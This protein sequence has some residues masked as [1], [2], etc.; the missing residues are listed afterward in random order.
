M[1]L[2]SNFKDTSLFMIRAEKGEVYIK[3]QRQLHS[4]GSSAVEDFIDLYLLYFRLKRFQ[5]GCNFNGYFVF[6]LHFPV[7]CFA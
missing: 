6:V 3:K 2:K 7:A 1:F 5:P 4:C